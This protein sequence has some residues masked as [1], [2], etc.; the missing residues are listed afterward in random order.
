MYSRPSKYSPVFFSSALPFCA[1]HS[2]SLLHSK[3]ST[4]RLCEISGFRRRV[5]HIFIILLLCEPGLLPTNA[6]QQTKTAVRTD[7]HNTLANVG[8]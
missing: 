1:A 4:T 2:I 5:A 6:T 7:R 3:I 8:P